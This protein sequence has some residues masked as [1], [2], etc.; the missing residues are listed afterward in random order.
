MCAGDLVGCAVL[1]PFDGA[2]CRNF[3]AGQIVAVPAAT[4]HSAEN[5]NCTPV[6]AMQAFSGSVSV[7]KMLVVLQWADCMCVFAL[8][9]RMHAWPLSKQQMLWTVRLAV[10]D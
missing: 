2:G 4:L 9:Q 6:R 1:G 8:H 7:L 10:E 3:S 5:P